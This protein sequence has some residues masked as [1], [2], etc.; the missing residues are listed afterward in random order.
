MKFHAQNRNI[1]EQNRLVAVLNDY[2]GRKKF[3]ADVLDLL[4]AKGMDANAYLQG[5]IIAGQSVS[6]A[7]LELLNLEIRGKYKDFDVFYTPESQLSSSVIT[8]PFNHRYLDYTPATDLQAICSSYSDHCSFV[9]VDKLSYRIINSVTQDMMN[10]V[11]FEMILTD[12]PTSIEQLAKNVLA[13]FDM[14]AVKVALFKDSFN[15]LPCLMV[16]DEYLDFIQ[17]GVIKPVTAITPLRTLIRLLK[18][19]HEMK[20]ISLDKECFDTLIGI[21][22]NKTKHMLGGDRDNFERLNGSAVSDI[23]L[24]QLPRKVLKKLKKYFD[25]NELSDE[26]TDFQIANHTRFRQFFV[27]KD[28]DILDVAEK[29]EPNLL[30]RLK[31]SK[32][33]D[34][35]GTEFVLNLLNDVPMNLQPLMSDE[36]ILELA[37]ADKG[38]SFRSLLRHLSRNT[39]ENYLYEVKASFI[40]SL[41]KRFSISNSCSDLVNL[42]NV[43]TGYD[44]GRSH[45]VFIAAAIYS[46][47]SRGH[48]FSYSECINLINGSNNDFLWITSDGIHTGLSFGWAMFKAGLSKFQSLFEACNPARCSQFVIGIE[49]GA[50]EG[51]ATRLIRQYSHHS[52]QDDIPFARDDNSC[53]AESIASLL[54][55]DRQSVPSFH[56]LGRSWKQALCDWALS[57]GMTLSWSSTAP[58]GRSI[59]VGHSPDGTKHAVVVDDGV[60]SFDPHPEQSFLESILYYLSFN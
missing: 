28:I 4:I 12:K 1:N 3:S 47:E 24:N 40:S 32:T 23:F 38:Y 33:L 9:P 57:I 31:S 30:M 41:N 6:S 35:I 22:H 29:I 8:R 54:R 14:N 37:N 52:D 50:S 27:R 43:I 58:E 56:L 42:S 17:S 11:Q 48:H 51:K 55:L 36:L 10:Y 16:C 60:F 19:E 39:P 13:G 46:Y 7:I 34:Q 49:C 25:I 59:A 20:N 44:C 26:R 53:L 21:Y 18:K 45:A 2:H 5:G 15:G